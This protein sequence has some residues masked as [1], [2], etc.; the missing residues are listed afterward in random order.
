MGWPHGRSNPQDLSRLEKQTHRPSQKKH[1]TCSVRPICSA[2]PMKRW[3]KMDRYTGSSSR[4]TRLRPPL[5]LPPS[6]PPSPP[7]TSPTSMATSPKGETVAVQPG[8]TTTVDT[9]WIRIAGPG[10]RR[11][12]RWCNVFWAVFRFQGGAPHSVDHGGKRAGG[13]KPCPSLS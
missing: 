12:R 1:N 4:L 13:L 11:C 9:S 2:M 10:F 7:A 8:S 5:L 6:P 3:A